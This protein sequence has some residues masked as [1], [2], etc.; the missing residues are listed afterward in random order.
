MKKNHG[1][2]LFFGIVIGVTVGI[3]TENLALWLSLG[4]VFGLT[5]FSQLGRGNADP[6]GEDDEEPESSAHE[7][8]GEEPE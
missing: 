6:E 7:L 1:T 5:A 3:I 2:G 8:E 4:I